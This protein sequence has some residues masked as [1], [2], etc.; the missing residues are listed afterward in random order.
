M[1][2]AHSV[3]VRWVGEGSRSGRFLLSVGKGSQSGSLLLSVGEVSHN[4]K[5]L[6]V[7]VLLQMV[8]C[9]AKCVVNRHEQTSLCVLKIKTINPSDGSLFYSIQT[10]S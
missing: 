5:P 3:T 4:A 7:N 2:Y 9:G 8:N 1:F 10:P 6:C